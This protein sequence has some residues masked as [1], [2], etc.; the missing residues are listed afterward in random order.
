LVEEIAVHIDAVGFGKVFGDQLADGGEVK[1][2]AC[3]LI[4]NVLKL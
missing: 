4:L 3:W 1:L 2:L